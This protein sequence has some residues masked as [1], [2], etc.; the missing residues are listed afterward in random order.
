M[1]VISLTPI[2]TVRSS[3]K[4]PEDD[5]WDNEPVHIALDELQFTSEAF[6]LSRI[7]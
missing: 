1:K 3:R 2:G 7:M 4:K 5:N 6:S